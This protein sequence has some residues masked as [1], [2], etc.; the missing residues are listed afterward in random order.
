MSTSDKHAPYKP[1]LYENADVFAI[2]ALAEGA[3]TEDQQK[4]ALNWIINDCCKTYD[5]SYRPGKPDD[6]VFAEG[7]RYVGTQLVMMTKLKI[8]KLGGENV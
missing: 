7:K 1:P 3:A 4:R 2:Q 8:G 5:I 6:T